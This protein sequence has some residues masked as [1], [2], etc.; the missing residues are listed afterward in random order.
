MSEETQNLAI[1]ASAI[2]F[3]VTVLMA[4]CVINGFKTTNCV[5]SAPSAEIARICYSGQH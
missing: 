3:V 2:A 1:I 5:Q 4:A